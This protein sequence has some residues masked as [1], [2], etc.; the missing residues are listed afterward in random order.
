LNAV[1]SESAS[2][3]RGATVALHELDISTMAVSLSLCGPRHGL[4]LVCEQSVT[5]VGI[6]QTFMAL[7]VTSD[8]DGGAG[9]GPGG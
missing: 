2:F 4:P 5:P 7:Y 1:A 3:T 9:G 6:G 8:G